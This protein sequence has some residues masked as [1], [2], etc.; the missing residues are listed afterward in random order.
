MTSSDLGARIGV[1]SSRVSG[2]DQPRDY[3]TLG[4]RRGP[5]LSEILKMR[6]LL[7]LSA[8]VCCMAAMD[9]AVAQ[10]A[11]NSITA[12][13]K[14]VGKLQVQVQKHDQAL[15]VVSQLLRPQAS[16][17]EC[18]GVCYL[19]NSSRP[20]AWKCDPGRRCDLHCTVSPPVGGCN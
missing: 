6:L 2:C 9:P 19:P 16:S 12:D 8:V 10:Q 1:R 5:S 13:Q 14:D 20:I 17:V 15:G 18:N 3:P 7:R 4:W 11:G